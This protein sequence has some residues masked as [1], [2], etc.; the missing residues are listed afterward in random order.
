MRARL[1]SRMDEETRASALAAA[2]FKWRTIGQQLRQFSEQF[3]ANKGPAGSGPQARPLEWPA[4]GWLV[5]AGVALALASAAHR[6]C[7]R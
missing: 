5:L 1:T 6:S 7:A 3:D 4:R 2:S